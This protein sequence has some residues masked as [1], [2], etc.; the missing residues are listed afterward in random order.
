VSP[1]PIG[2]TRHDILVAYYYILR[3]HV[4]FREL[5]ADW[6]RKRFSPEK[7]ARRLQLQLEAL[8]YKVT[9]E[10]NPEPEPPVEQELT[11]TA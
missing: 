3:D 1:R 10:A 11:A 8:G 6:H 4:P 2:A 5:G 7:R 9:I